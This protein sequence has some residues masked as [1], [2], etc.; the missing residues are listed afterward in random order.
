MRVHG[1]RLSWA[2]GAR[3]DS[4]AREKGTIS[5]PETDTYDHSVDALKKRLVKELVAPLIEVRALS[6]IDVADEFGVRVVADAMYD[7]VDEW[8]Y[9]NSPDKEEEA[10]PRPRRAA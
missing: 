10:R 9:A 7:V 8:Y 3:R 1:P 6:L 4:L 5:M 2:M